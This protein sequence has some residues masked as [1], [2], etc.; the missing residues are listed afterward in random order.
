MDHL[1]AVVEVKNIISPEF[2]DRIVPLINK[3]AKKNLEIRVGLDKNI[4]NVKGYHLNFETPTNLFYWNYIKKEI[5][6][7]YVYYKIKF[8][9][10]DSSKINQIEIGRAHV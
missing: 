1:E 6:R 10:M 7:L 3:K 4:R 8:P 5:E 9:E 2:I